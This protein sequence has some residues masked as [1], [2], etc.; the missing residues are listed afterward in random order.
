MG[1]VNPMLHPSENDWSEYRGRTKEESH[2]NGSRTFWVLF[3]LLTAAAVVGGYFAYVA[4][5]KQNIQ[6]THLFA[7]EGTVSAIGQR[8]DS[9][10]AKLREMS[11]GWEG[12]GQRFTALETKVN[13]KINQSRRY[14]ETL[15]QQAHQQMSAELDAR[16]SALDARLRQVEAEQTAE[17]SQ[18]Q[19]VQADLKQD[20]NQEVA[21]VRDETSRDL[22]DVRQQADANSRDVNTLSQRLDR[23]RVDF[24]LTKG[25][26]KELVPGISVQIS[27]TNPTYQRY[28]GSI[29]L[30]Q[31]RRTLWL[32]EQ[33]VHE[34]VRF[35]HKEGGEAYELV[36]TD[37][38]RKA[39]VGYL[40]VPVKQETGGDALVGQRATTGASEH[41]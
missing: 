15:T 34:P 31:D 37:V 6:V 24:E 33:S 11:G 28:R 23:Q 36:V 21:S 40:L 39:A 20:I 8:V 25:Q 41:E 1:V 35:F 7:S 4:L 29:W 14:A 18:M 27:G 2:R 38:T 16:A 26:S 19:Q 3:L 30:L 32:R 5:K 22:S 12:V 13:D 10:E 17:R 9:A